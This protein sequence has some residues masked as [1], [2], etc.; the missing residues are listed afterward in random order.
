QIALA[1][2]LAFKRPLRRWL[3]WAPVALEDAGVAVR[4]ATTVDAGFLAALAPD[5]LI[6]ATG[7]PWP[8]PDGFAGARDPLE[9]L[10]LPGRLRHRV[11][12]V[13][14]GQIGAETAWHLATTGCAV[15]LVEA[16]AGFGRDV[17]LIARIA[18]VPAL[19][20]AGVATRFSTRATSFA[21]GRLGLETATG[22]ETLAVEDVVVAF[23]RPDPAPVPPVD[24]GGIPTYV[25]G[26]RAGGRGLYWAGRT[27]V[28]AGNLV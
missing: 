8:V 14:A 25:V 11:A 21:A 1:A 20:A 23:R 28:R 10:A 16:G 27:G 22:P 6:E 4:L 19:A 18:L 17:D 12:V 7:A 26:E 3:D 5:A 24:G 15:T 2:A 9:A 13:G